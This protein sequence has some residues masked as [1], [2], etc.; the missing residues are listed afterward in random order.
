MSVDAEAYLGIN[1]YLEGINLATY[2]HTNLIYA[3]VFKFEGTIVESV[4]L[5]VNGNAT[6]TFDVIKVVCELG[7]V[8]LNHLEGDLCAVVESI[9]EL[10]NI[11]SRIGNFGAKLIVDN[12]AI[13]SKNYGYLFLSGCNYGV[14]ETLVVYVNVIAYGLINRELNRDFIAC[15][16]NDTYTVLTVC[17]DG[18]ARYVLTKGL[19]VLEELCL[20]VFFRVEYLYI[21]INGFT[22]VSTFHLDLGFL[23]VD[24]EGVY[25][26]VSVKVLKRNGVVTVSGEL[27]AGLIRNNL[28]VLFNRYNGF[29]IP[30]EHNVGIGDTAVLNA[31][32]ITCRNGLF[33]GNLTADRID[34]GAEFIGNNYL[35]HSGGTELISESIENDGIAIV[36]LGKSY[37]SFTIIGGLL[38]NNGLNVGLVI[39]TLIDC[40]Y[41]LL[42]L[43]ILYERNRGSVARNLEAE[44]FG[45]ACMVYSD[46]GV[47]TAFGYLEGFICIE[48]CEKLA[49]FVINSEHCKL[50]D[51]INN[52][53][54]HLILEEIGSLEGGGVRRA[55]AYSVLNCRSLADYNHGVF[56]S[57]AEII[58]Y[59]DHMLALGFD[60]STY[61]YLA[62]NE[63]TDVGAKLDAVCKDSGS[64]RIGV[65]VLAVSDY[66]RLL[67]PVV[68]GLDA[69]LRILCDNL[70][71]S[72][73]GEVCNFLV[74]IAGFLIDEVFAINSVYGILFIHCNASIPRGA[75]PCAFANERVLALDSKFECTLIAVECENVAVCIVN[76]VV[77]LLQSNSRNVILGRSE[78]SFPSVACSIKDSYFVSSGFDGV[79]GCSIGDSLAVNLYA[80]NRSI[81]VCIAISPSNHRISIGFTVGY[82]ANVHLLDGSVDYNGVFASRVSG[83]VLT[84]ED[85]LAGFV[86]LCAGGVSREAC[87][88]GCLNIAGFATYELD[89][90]A[91]RVGSIANR[92]VINVELCRRN[93][94]VY[95]YG[96]GCRLIASF[97]NSVEGVHSL[98]SKL[99]AGGISCIRGC[100]G[101]L[102]E[103]GVQCNVIR[104]YEFY[105]TC[106]GGVTRGQKS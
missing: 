4:I 88:T 82:V 91:I 6:H 87:A 85:I 90:I 74:R 102:D 73:G 103:N 101:C 50:I 16:I 22:V 49:V 34:A 41:E 54:C 24:G 9:G 19:A 25:L 75:A 10:E 23:G 64:I 59:G 52:G 104:R 11:I 40:D 86:K 42:F 5:T 62:I 68:I 98:S 51:F 37:P 48:N 58:K 33:V 99:L 96:V 53:D 46:N 81:G 17:G 13:L 93:L 60:R 36:I 61:I 84:I 70:V 28:T 20:E 94:S 12:L 78:L 29:I 65:Q 67:L 83:F 57:I 56:T 44:G 32:K 26:L 8:G 30:C 15:G 92:F 79:D 39:L 77:F 43:S 66:C 14:G 21:G 105:R 27:V 100:S 2:S 1:G 89:V 106:I 76:L 55:F 97:V 72:F 45:I 35:V 3:I 31:C 18:I 69:Y 38:N 47:R 95:G 80:R 63:D 7:Y 71:K